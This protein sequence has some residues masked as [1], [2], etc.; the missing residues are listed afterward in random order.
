MGWV[1]V[2][3]FLFAVVFLIYKWITIYNDFMFLFNK[4]SQKLNDVNVVFQQRLD[5]IN[6]L[7][8]LVQKYSLHEYNTIKETIQARGK[9]P[10]TDEAIEKSLINVNA[11]KEEYPELKANSLFESLMEKDSEIEMSLRDTRKEFNRIVQ[12]YNTEVCQFPRN[13]VADFHHIKKMTYF[14]LDGMKPYDGKEIMGDVK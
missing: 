1:L 8:S 13:V 3:L 11:V 14:A 6:A 7:A 4:A 12:S 2:I 5:N 10:V 9:E